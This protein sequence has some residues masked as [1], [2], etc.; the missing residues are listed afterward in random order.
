MAHET[1]TNGRIGRFFDNSSV[2]ALVSVLLTGLLGGGAIGY[3]LQIHDAVTYNN[4]SSYIKSELVNPGYVSSD[5]LEMEN[6][7]QQIQA[8]GQELSH[9]TSEIDDLQQSMRQFLVAS[10]ES[11]SSVKKKTTEQLTAL[12]QKKSSLL[13]TLTEQVQTYEAQTR[14][15]LSTPDAVIS[16]EA[17]DTPLVDYVATIASHHYYSEDFL[18]T[19]LPHKISTED[20]KVFY[21]KDA[22]EKV[23]VVYSGLIYNNKNFEV[24]N[25]KR[26]FTMNLKKYDNGLIPNYY[27]ESLLTIGC[28]KKYSYLSF[29]LGHLDNGYTCSRRL[30]VYYMDDDG[31]FK[32]AQAFSLYGDMPVASYS[33]PIYNTRTVKI[34]V[35]DPSSWGEYALADVYLV[36]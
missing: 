9:K 21:D 13:P 16:G 23:N 24:N 1:E 11:E 10:G 20:G 28:D 14:A 18:N 8:I 7:F 17:M 35:S 30:T 12:L 3:N 31:N 4:I 22:P 27:D 26:H 34:T 5:I 6:P 29:T 33:V 15:T 25:G 2:G 32:E 36:R 19:F